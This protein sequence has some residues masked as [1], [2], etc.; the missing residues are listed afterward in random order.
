[1]I[2]WF[3]T[4]N[5]HKK[6]EMIAILRDSSKAN[7][8]LKIPGEAG[9]DFDPDETGKS[10]LENAMLKAEV[11]YRL[12]AQNELDRKGSRHQD[13]WNASFSQTWPILAEDSGICVDALGGKPGIFSA[14]YGGK[15]LSAEEKNAKLL[16][17]LGDNSKR[18]ARFVCAMVLYYG[19]DR[20]FAAQE[21][22]EG[23]L[24]KN[25]ERG[26]GGFGY[27]PIL[28]INSLGRTVAELQAEEKNLYSHRG[29]AAR[30]LAKIL[31]KDDATR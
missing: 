30:A 17:E 29:K 4:G 16:A 13:I 19:P 18:T 22:M 24:V 31:F 25:A 23:E 21:T 6:K 26:S 12:L 11:L 3:A 14:R 9:I 1:M 20:F 8:E 5:I 2:I 7:F 27:D 10:F 15:E 28:Y